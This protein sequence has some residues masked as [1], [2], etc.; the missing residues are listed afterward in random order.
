MKTSQML[1][2]A[3]LVKLATSNGFWDAH[4]NCRLGMRMVVDL[5]M[6]G[7][8]TTGEG[9]TIRVIVAFDGRGCGPVPEEVLEIRDMAG[10]PPVSVWGVAKPATN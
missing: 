2:T 1:G 6:R 8:H 4:P 3:R 10:D 5:E 9:E 7:T